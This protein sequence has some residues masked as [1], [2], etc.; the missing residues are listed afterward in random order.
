MQ[1]SDPDRIL[2]VK[3]F[4]IRLIAFV[5]TFQM[6]EMFEVFLYACLIQSRALIGAIYLETATFVH[7]LQL[8]SN[9]HPSFAANALEKTSSLLIPHAPHC[10]GRARVSHL[11]HANILPS[12]FPFH[13]NRQQMFC[14]LTSIPLGI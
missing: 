1:T 9:F 2:Q 4:R 13:K 10:L 14:N 7:R 8:L 5:T 11:A 6:M 12:C 3:T